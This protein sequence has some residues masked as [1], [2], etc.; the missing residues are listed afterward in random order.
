MKLLILFLNIKL[1]KETLIKSKFVSE[2]R[3]IIWINFHWLLL[4]K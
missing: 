4:E 3:T 1:I 2:G